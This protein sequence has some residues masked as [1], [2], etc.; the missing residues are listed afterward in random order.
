MPTTENSGISAS[1][2]PVYGTLQV[3][4][5]HSN[6]FHMLLMHL[7]KSELE[8]HYFELSE[9]TSNSKIIACLEIYIILFSFLPRPCCPTSRPRSGRWITTWTGSLF[10]RSAS[11]TSSGTGHTCCRLSRML[12]ITTTTGVMRFQS[13]I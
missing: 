8:V 4:V 1:P 3:N 7:T 11:S 5:F 2:D 6:L 9:I 12:L 10:L 13:Q